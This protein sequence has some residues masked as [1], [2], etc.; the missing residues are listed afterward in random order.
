[1]DARLLAGCSIT[2]RAP[3]HMSHE[4]LHMWDRRAAKLVQQPSRPKRQKEVY[5]GAASAPEGGELSCGCC[6][7][8][9]TASGPSSAAG[10]L[11]RWAPSSSE[12]EGWD[13]VGLWVPELGT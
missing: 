4:S 6:H 7:F 8:T 11:L 5:R 3:G 9:C 13:V 1:M 10:L 12:R 2:L